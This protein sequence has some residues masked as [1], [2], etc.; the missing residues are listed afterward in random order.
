V[1]RGCVFYFTGQIPDADAV[2][3]RALEGPYASDSRRVF[4]MGKTIDGAD[5][6][7]FRVLNAAFEC[8]ADQQH[9]YYRQS[10]IANTDPRTFPPG[11]AVTNCDETSVSFAE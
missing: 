1:S 4:W 6:A 7:T 2:T 11:R 9:A 10:V 5:P 8:S 3:F